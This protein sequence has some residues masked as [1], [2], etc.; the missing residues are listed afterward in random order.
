[1]EAI[2][3]NRSVVLIAILGILF[4]ITALPGKIAFAQTICGYDQQQQPIYCTPEPKERKTK[5]PVPVRINP[6]RIKPTLTATETTTAT[7]T[8]TSTS[9]PVPTFTSNP[10][11]TFTQTPIPNNSSVLL[12]TQAGSPPSG[13]NDQPTPN[14]ASLILFGLG[15]LLIIVMAILFIRRRMPSIGSEGGEPGTG[16]GLSIGPKHDDLLTN[17]PNNSS[18]HQGHGLGIGPKHDDL[19]TNDPNNSSGHQGHGLGIG[20]KHD[21]LLTN[22]EHG[23]DIGPKHDDLFTSGNDVDPVPNSDTVSPGD[24]LE[25]NKGTLDHLNL[26]HADGSEEIKIDRIRPG[27]ENDPHSSGSGV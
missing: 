3:K 8:S 12:P 2:M 19:L 18:G 15:F 22:G 27:G 5:T 24:S 23:L 11:A 25:V 7:P 9:T 21:D 16:H 1:M 13:D 4:V 20:P 17:D 10:T 14:P 26:D 6:T